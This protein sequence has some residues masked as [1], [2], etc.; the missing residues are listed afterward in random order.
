MIENFI[1][2]TLNIN[3]PVVIQRSHRLGKATPKNAIGQKANAPRPIIANFLDFR[4]REA[5][6]AART[7]LR[8]PQGIAEDFPYEVRKARESLIP[9]LKELKRNNKKCSIVWPAKLLSDGKIIKEVDVT[10]FCQS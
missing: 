1:R 8:H 5:I 3:E 10:E 2:N 6:R 9:Q 4:Q 7:I